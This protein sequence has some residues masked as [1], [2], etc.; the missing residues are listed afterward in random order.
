M[1]N[2]G[3]IRHVSF[4]AIPFQ[5]VV[6]PSHW[7]A[8]TKQVKAISSPTTLHSPHAV[9]EGTYPPVGFSKPHKTQ[10]K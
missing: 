8:S 10:I 2:K 5:P 7:L 9:Y 3:M 4:Y 1:L 6:S